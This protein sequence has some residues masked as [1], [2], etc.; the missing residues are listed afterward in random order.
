MHFELR[1]DCKRKW[2]KKKRKR[3]GG[4]PEGRG[5]GAYIPVPEMEG[6]YGGSLL[7]LVLVLLG[8]QKGEREHDI[9]R[10]KGKQAALRVKEK[11]RDDAGI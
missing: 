1:L 5:R 4:F 10:D 6:G 11:D 8:D 3:K 7:R 2:M 9:A